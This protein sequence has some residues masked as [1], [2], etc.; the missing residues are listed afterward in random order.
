MLATFERHD[1]GR[2]WGIVKESLIELGYNVGD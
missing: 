2:T 1:D